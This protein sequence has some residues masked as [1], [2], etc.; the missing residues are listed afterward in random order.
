MEPNISSKLPVCSPTDINW[1]K[2]CGNTFS[3]L[4]NF[5]RDSPEKTPFFMLSSP[6][7]T[8]VFV[9]IDFAISMLSIKLTPA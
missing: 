6:S 1:A 7:I 8:R 2:V 4:N 3:L 9:V 5:V